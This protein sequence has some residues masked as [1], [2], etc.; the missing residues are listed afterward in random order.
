VIKHFWMLRATLVLFY[1]G[2]GFVRFDDNGVDYNDNRQKS[3]DCNQRNQEIKALKR[4]VVAPNA[5]ATVHFTGSI[6]LEQ[7]GQQRI[8][9]A[10]DT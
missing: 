10:R 9:P 4:H 1:F 2:E 6:R 8:K 7:M 5:L 3:G